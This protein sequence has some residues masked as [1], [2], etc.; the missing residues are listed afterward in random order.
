[1]HQPLHHLTT[2]PVVDLAVVPPLPQVIHSH[3]GI[4]TVKSGTLRCTEGPLV[5]LFADKLDQNKEK[6]GGHMCTHTEWN[7]TLMFTLQ[8]NGIKFPDT[9]GCEQAM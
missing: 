7:S 3:M 5:Q 9:T 6:G 8:N 4:A 1:M 2:R